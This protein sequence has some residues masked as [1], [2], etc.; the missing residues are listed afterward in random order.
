[1]SDKNII[2]MH[3]LFPACVFDRIKNKKSKRVFV[4]EGRP[5]LESARLACRELAKRKMKPTLISDNMAGFLFYKKWVKEVWLAYQ[6]RDRSG[7]LCQI[8]SL[9]LGV[10]GRVHQV[11]VNAHR[12]SRR[13]PFMGKNRDLTHFNG[14]R[15]VP[16]SFTGYAPMTE[17]VPAK[18]LSKVHG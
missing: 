10:L 1:M 7:A 3:G 12:S 2:L 13:L 17:W 14:A 15:V 8:G 16:D 9:I 4:L 5:G 11:P 6:E 18:Y